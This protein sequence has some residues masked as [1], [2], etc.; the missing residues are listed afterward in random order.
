MAKQ[1]YRRYNFT[2]N[3]YA[4]PG[5]IPRERYCNGFTVTNIG[6]TPLKINDAILFP[7][8]TPATVQGDSKSFGGNEGEIYIGKL[9]LSF[10]QPVLA[11]PL[12]E[13]I[14]KYYIPDEEEDQ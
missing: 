12:C 6:D 14:Q 10:L 11:N 4:L 7:S 3:N 5:D 2:T 8:A 9:S 13:I 1:Q